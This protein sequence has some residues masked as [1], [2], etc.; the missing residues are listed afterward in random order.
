MIGETIGSY[1]VIREIGSGGMGVVYLAQ[2]TVIGR[3]AAIK[4][5]LPDLS[6]NEEMVNRMFNEARMCAVQQR[7][8]RDVR[9]G[10]VGAA[11]A[12]VLEHRGEHLLRSGAARR[13]G[14]VLR[15][16]P[17]ERGSVHHRHASAPADLPQWRVG[18]QPDVHQLRL[19][20][21]DRRHQRISS[22][23]LRSVRERRPAVRGHLDAADVHERAIRRPDLPGRQAVLRPGPCGRHRRV[24]RSVRGRRPSLQRRQRG[25]VHH[26][27]GDIGLELG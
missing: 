7:Q 12:G 2:H 10:A 17:Q 25:E 4:M 21:P 19:L 20:R 13:D 18:H 11:D 27:G 1:R 14:R 24:L 23:V 6:G 16:L 8:P 26:V 3:M 9:D 5:L 22:G 15:Q